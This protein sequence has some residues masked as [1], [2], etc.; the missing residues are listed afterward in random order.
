MLPAVIRLPRS[1]L[2]CGDDA[3]ERRLHML[4]GGGFLQLPEIGLGGVLQRDGR[5]IGVLL[6]VEILLGDRILREQGFPAFQ[7][8]LGQHDIGLGL[9]E[10]RPGLR[11][12]LV[13][14]RRVQLRQTCP[15]F[16]FAPISTAKERT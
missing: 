16:T 9:L 4:E 6:D 7:R 11:D 14:F 3:V 1:T 5:V 15:F 10:L 12:L 2:R 13:E 8:R